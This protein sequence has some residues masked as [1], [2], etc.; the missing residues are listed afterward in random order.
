MVKNLLL[1]RGATCT[2]AGS[3][4]GR[5][6]SFDRRLAFLW[7]PLPL[8]D[9]WTVGSPFMSARSKRVKAYLH[10]FFRSPFTFFLLWKEKE[11]WPFFFCCRVTSF[12]PHNDKS[13]TKLMLNTDQPRDD[14]SKWTICGCGC[15]FLEGGG[16]RAMS[17]QKRKGSSGPGIHG[18][19]RRC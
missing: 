3:S 11:E 16:R 7:S 14:R 5:S 2:Q 1:R 13:A 4:V 12:W 18:P 6:V 8:I 19:R 10:H 17:T 9:P 15:F